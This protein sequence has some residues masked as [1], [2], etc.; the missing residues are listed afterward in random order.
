LVAPLW[1]HWPERF[2][3]LALYVGAAVPDVIDGLAGPFK[4]GLGQWIGHSL[5]GLFALCVPV[6]LLLTWALRRSGPWV[7]RVAPS[8]WNLLVRVSQPSNAPPRAAIASRWRRLGFVSFSV[9]VGALSHLV[10][11]F[12]SHG[13]FLWFFPWYD[14][15][16]FFPSWWYTCWFKIP[17]PGYRDPYSAGPHLVV[18]VLLGLVGIALFLVPLGARAKGPGVPGE[19]RSRHDER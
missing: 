14:N 17:L 13:N 11:D 19:A 4:G 16:H 8:M 6:G 12:I 18:W 15:P 1:W 9:W 7:Q 5:V 3:V 10:I 2:D